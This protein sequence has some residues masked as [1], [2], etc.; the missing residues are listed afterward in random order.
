MDYRRAQL[1]DLD[2]VVSLSRESFLE[3]PLYKIIRK[4]CKDEVAY[5]RFITIS[6]RLFIE[7]LLI[8]AP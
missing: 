5:K 3:D 2:T 4:Q 1:F 7:T 6:Q 8:A